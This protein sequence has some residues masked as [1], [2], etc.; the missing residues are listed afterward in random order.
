MFSKVN[1]IIAL[2]TVVHFFTPTTA[3]ACI[4]NFTVLETLQIA[5]GNKTE[6]PV[7][8]VICP[9]TVFNFTNTSNTLETNGNASYLC[10]A[11]GSSANNCLVVGGEFQLVSA[12]FPFGRSSKDNILISGFTFTKAELATGAVGAPGKFTMRDCIFRVRYS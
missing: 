2:L 11:D 3:S 10:G 8:Y 1:I 12:V 4:N 5:R 9:N 7:T 6:T